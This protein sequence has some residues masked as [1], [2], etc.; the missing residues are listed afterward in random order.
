VLAELGA[1]PYHYYWVKA[2]V[3]FQEAIVKSNSPLLVDVAKADAQ[4]ACD[5]LP[6]GQRCSTCWSAE[7]AEAL[8]SI[9]EKAGLVEQGRSWAGQVKQGL[10]LG[11]QSVVLEATLSAYDELAWRECK[12]R[13]GLVR[14]AQLPAGVGRKLLTYYAYFKPTQRDQ[15]PAY[16]RLDQELHKQIRQLARFRLGCHKLEVESA[17]H[18]RPR[19]AWSSRTCT[20]CSDAHRASLSCA[21]DDEYHMIFECERFEAL[22]IDEFAPGT[23]RFTPGTRTALDR[24]QKSV[25]HFMESDPR[26]VLHFVSRCMDILDADLTHTHLA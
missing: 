24:A 9:G 21:V 5:E 4:L 25:K 10:P 14:D 20:R 6:G 23:R 13:E 26:I 18:L 15:V 3:R 8:E 19:P 22:R 1:K 2:L 17:R 7:L 16:L 12:D 11:C